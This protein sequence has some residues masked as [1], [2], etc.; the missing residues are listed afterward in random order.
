MLT[1]QPGLLAQHVLSPGRADPLRRTI[2][3]AHAHGRQAD[4]QPSLGSLAPTDL[5]PLRAFE[6]RVFGHGFDVRHM[7]H[8]W[9]TAACDREDQLH[10]GRIDFLVPGDADSPARPRVLSACR[11]GADSP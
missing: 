11:N 10:V 2:G 9:A 8:P 7:P 4:R 5:P 3:N 6:H 1:H